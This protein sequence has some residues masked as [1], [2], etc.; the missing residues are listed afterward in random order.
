[1]I[2]ALI[3]AEEHGVTQANVEQMK[4]SGNPAI[5]RLLGSAE[6]SGKLLGL[7]RDWAARAVKAVGN[8]GEMHQRNV[9]SASPLKLPRGFNALWNKGGLMYA[10]PIR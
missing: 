5:Q 7:D 2:F 3:E 10:P 4:A 6:D 9:G 1:V 8:Y